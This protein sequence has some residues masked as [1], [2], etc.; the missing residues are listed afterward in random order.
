MKKITI[1][2]PTY[3]RAY[4]LPKLY[5][6]LR[7]QTDKS[8]I[9]LIVDDGSTDDTK[10]VLEQFER[11]NIIE[12]EYYFKQNGGKN[13][14]M[15]F[16]NTVCKTDYIACVDSDDYLTNNCIETLLSVIPECD[17]DEKCCGIVARRFK[18]NKEPFM[19]GWPQRNTKLFFSQLEKEY[20]YNSDTFL[21]FKTNIIKNYRFPTID[22]EKFITES[23]FYNQFMHDFTMLT[24]DE[25]MYIAEYMPD[26]YTSSGKDLFFK[27]PKGYY[28]AL[29]MYANI[30]IKYKR[31]FKDRVFYM[32]YMYSWEKI[33][34]FKNLFK[35]EFK[36]NL[37]YKICGKL[38]MVFV[39]NKL[40][41][42]YK[43]FREKNV[44][45]G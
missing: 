6:S 21:I 31:S 3:N 19:N 34:S 24:C 27:N 44:K 4:L 2:T 12:I 18:P 30:S 15:D 7:N 33:F 8:F 14:A 17:K 36:F 42:E 37:F 22:G 10:E 32:A 23:V 25:A 29:K 43:S 38:G 5:E 26:G 9:W 20:G 28:Y 39:F 40:K 16:A 11:D 45:N 13:T 1:F 41:K 35:N